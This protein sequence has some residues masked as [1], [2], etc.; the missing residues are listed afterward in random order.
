MIENSERGITINKT[1]AWTML[2]GLATLFFWGGT[3][4]AGLQSATSQ[5]NAAVAELKIDSTRRNDA[6]DARVRSLEASTVGTAS[7]ISSFRRDMTDTREEMRRMT[8]VLLR[9]ETTLA[10]ISPIRP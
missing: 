1:L 6:I 8:T 2:V 3:T 9:V 4:V 5:L 10:R 7:E